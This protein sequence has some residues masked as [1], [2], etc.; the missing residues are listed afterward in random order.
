M[1]RSLESLSRSH[2]MDMSKNPEGVIEDVGNQNLLKLS[3]SI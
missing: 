2:D 1:G 3:K